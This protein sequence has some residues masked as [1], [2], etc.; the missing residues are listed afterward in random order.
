MIPDRDDLAW[1]MDRPHVTVSE[2]PWVSF[3]HAAPAPLPEWMAEG[4]CAATPFAGDVFFS[5]KK[6]DQEL[7]VRLCR[8][9][10]VARLCLD[11]ALQSGPELE[12]VWGGTTTHHRRS[13]LR[14]KKKGVRAS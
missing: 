4:T 3:I 7:A 5:R 1:W 13:V 11:F 9:C 10:P 12:G 14:H 6:K 8:S 2:K